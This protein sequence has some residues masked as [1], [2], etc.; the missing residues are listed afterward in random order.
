MDDLTVVSLDLK[1]GLVKGVAMDR[2]VSVLRAGVSVLTWWCGVLM[3]LVPVWFL[4]ATFG[5]KFDLIDWEVGLGLMIN[6]LGLGVLLTALVSGVL[7]LVLISAHWFLA[8]RLFG[9]IA[10]PV[11]AALLGAGGIGWMTL[12]LDQHDQTPYLIDISTDTQDPPGFTQANIRRRLVSDQ[13][14]DY[15]LKRDD[16]GQAYADA[17]ATYYP[18]L[19]SLYL[20][21]GPEDAF[22]RALLTAREMGWHVGAA[23]HDAGMFEATAESFWFGFT[24]DMVV[25]V[26]RLEDGEGAVIDVRSLSRREMHDLGRNARRVAAFLEAVQ[27]EPTDVDAWSEAGAQAG[28]GSE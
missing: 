18:Q 28:T 17:Q 24:D 6:Q 1:S 21:M 7:G 4:L 22:R 16:D 13:P 3:L 23:S 9:V 27:I 2:I 25:R 10:T 11:W 5:V 8:K 12:S 26:R 20:E 19:T 15:T 14:L